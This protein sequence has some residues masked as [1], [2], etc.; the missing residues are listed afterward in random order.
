[1]GK[2]SSSPAKSEFDICLEALVSAKD[3]RGLAEAF[4]YALGFL[5]RNSS[6]VLDQLAAAIINTLESLVRKGEAEKIRQAILESEI[7]HTLKCSLN[8]F[9]LSTAGRILWEGPI[10]KEKPPSDGSRVPL[11]VFDG[12]WVPAP[13]FETPFA[14][15]LP[16]EEPCIPGGFG[17]PLGAPRNIP[18]GNLTSAFSSLGAPLL[19]GTPSGY[20]IPKKNPPSPLK[21]RGEMKALL[22]KIKDRKQVPPA[23]RVQRRQST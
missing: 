21:A 10:E 7:S 1:M 8:D 12:A 18:G 5:K 16:L 23:L 3:L 15:F 14:K 19:G 2:S 6:R 22:R 20:I 9:Y 13:D 4:D 17:S 11:S